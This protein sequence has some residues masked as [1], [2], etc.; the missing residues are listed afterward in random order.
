MKIGVFYVVSQTAAAEIA[1]QGNYPWLDKLSELTGYEFEVTD[2][3]HV[4][5][6]DL[7]FDFMGTGGT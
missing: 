7:L 4:N 5:D 2:F 1:N 3:D 6:Y